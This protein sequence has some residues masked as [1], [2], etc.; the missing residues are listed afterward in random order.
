M[1]AIKPIFCLLALCL[2]GTT[3]AAP[4]PQQDLRTIIRTESGKNHFDMDALNHA[5]EN[6]SA[7]AA[8]YPTKFDNDSDLQRARKDVTV[9]A[10]ILT[11]MLH[12]VVKPQDKAYIPLLGQLAQVGWMAHNMDLPAAEVADQAYRQLLKHLQGKALLQAKDEYGR[13]LSSSG[14]T[15]AA[16]KMLREALDGGYRASNKSLGLILLVQGKKEEALK[17]L[18]AYVKDFPQDQQGQNI[19]DAATHGRVEIKSS[20]GK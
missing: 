12:E 13:F 14:Q 8:D 11:Y 16:E 9:L 3:L 6:L 18:R 15:D 2:M 20:K 1:R 5:I 10:K 17:H 7:H 19:L 4:Y